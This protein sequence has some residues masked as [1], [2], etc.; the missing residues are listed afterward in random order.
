MT[1]IYAKWYKPPK[2]KGID[3]Q[4]HIIGF[5]LKAR[6]T[7]Q[8]KYAAHAGDGNYYDAAD[9]GG[10]GDV[11]NEATSQTIDKPEGNVSVYAIK[12]GIGIDAWVKAYDVIGKAGPD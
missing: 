6:E 5:G 2:K 10:L 7:E 12:N 1:E 8:L 3:F 11:L 4:L 9:S